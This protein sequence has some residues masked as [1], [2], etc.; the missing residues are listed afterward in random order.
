[1]LILTVYVSVP[2]RQIAVKHFQPSLTGGKMKGSI[3]ITFHQEFT[4]ESLAA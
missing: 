2:N 1:M 3:N 4:D